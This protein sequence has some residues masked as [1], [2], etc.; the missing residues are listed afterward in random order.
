LLRARVPRWMFWFHKAMI[1]WVLWGKSFKISPIF[2]DRVACSRAVQD[3]VQTGQQEAA[4]CGLGHC[5]SSCYC[6]PYC[7]Y[8]NNVPDLINFL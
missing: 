5:L 4:H 2:S 8:S 3:Y 6:L 1:T 7:T